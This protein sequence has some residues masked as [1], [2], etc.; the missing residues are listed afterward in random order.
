MDV[1]TRIVDRKG[2]SDSLELHKGRIT[3]YNGLMLK[4]QGQLTLRCKEL[5]AFVL[6]SRASRATRLGATGAWRLTSS[7]A[8][9]F[10]KAPPKTSVEEV[11]LR[12]QNFGSV[13]IDG[14]CVRQRAFFA[15][16]LA[17]KWEACELFVRVDNG[18]TGE[19]K[20]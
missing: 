1:S 16:V 10:E 11:H 9:I 13:N 6:R 17:R 3:G 2:F 15:V 19:H 20:T 14:E 7:S 18:P 5:L 8:P 4:L 12:H